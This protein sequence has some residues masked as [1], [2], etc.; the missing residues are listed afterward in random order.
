MSRGIVI[1]RV[2]SG[3]ISRNSEGLST[4]IVNPSQTERYD[5]T[6]VFINRESWRRDLSASYDRTKVRVPSSLA[7]NRAEGRRVGPQRILLGSGASKPSCWVC[8]D[9][10]RACSVI[11]QSSV[12]AGT[13]STFSRE[14][15]I[16]R[17]ACRITL[18]MKKINF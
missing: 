16:A 9:G 7:S 12:G 15:S 11:I 13:G 8:T 18:Y 17:G 1:G 6:D 2:D 4:P 5:D 14:S 10:F 3:I